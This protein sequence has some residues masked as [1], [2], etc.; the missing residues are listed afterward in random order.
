MGNAAPLAVDLAG[1]GLRS[2]V[3]LA[4]GTAGTLDELAGVVDLGSVGAV[5][6]KSITP[7]PRDGNAAWRVAPVKSGMMNAVGLANPG[8]ERFVGEHAPRIP[9]MPCP[10]VVSVA[11]FSVDDYVRVAGAI[12]ALG[13]ASAIELNVSCPNVHSGTEFGADPELLAEVVRAVR[14]ATP[15]TRLLAKLP[16]VVVATPHTIVDLARAAIEPTGA[17]P[18]G[19]NQ[20]PGV[21]ALSLCNTT[22]AL[23][24]DVRTRRPLL[25]NGPGGLSGPAVH[26]A[27]VRLV[28]L[29]HTGIARDAG[30]PIVGIGGVASWQDA[31]E[32]VLAGASAVQVGT[33]LFADPRAPKKIARG[34]SKW[35]RSQRSP[36]LSDLVGSVEF[37]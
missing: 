36:G 13:V 9:D 17:A 27:V 18:S 21:D 3:L 37:R 22:P 19:P 12:D 25:G 7:E 1:L 28:H 29:A 10:V 35:V 16:P 20:R 2:P 23:G 31:A 11:G 4:A 26:Q 8:L 30:V 6:T 24:I 15:N 32:L 33:A 5:V 14:T 34:L